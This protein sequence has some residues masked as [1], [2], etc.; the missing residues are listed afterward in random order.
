MVCVRVYMQKHD[1][2]Y[3]RIWCVYGVSVQVAE[4]LNSIVLEGCEKI[5]LREIVQLSSDLDRHA[6]A[7]RNL[8]PLLAPSCTQ[9]TELYV[10][11]PTY[12]PA[13]D[14]ALYEAAAAGV[15]KLSLQLRGWPARTPSRP[16]PPLHRLCVS[17]PLTE[18]IAGMLMVLAPNLTVL[19]VP[20]VVVQTRLYKF[21]PWRTVSVGQPCT[22]DAFIRGV[23]TCKAHPKCSGVSQ[24]ELC[25][26]RICLS[27]E[28]VKIGRAHV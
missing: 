19:E 15:P 28:E 23:K 17:E 10:T 26:L 18:L 24:W 8:L 6:N 7:F 27:A 3:V 5:C 2:G 13:I 16:F 1:A 11:F 21:V 20:R 25:E 14:E 22:L 9:D 4:K 12:H